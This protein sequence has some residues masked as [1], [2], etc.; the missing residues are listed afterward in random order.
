MARENEK[1]GYDAYS[2]AWRDDRYA[3]QA[4]YD[5]HYWDA[6]YSRGGRGYDANSSRH[7]Y[8]SPSSRRFYSTDAHRSS[9]PSRW[10][11][12]PSSSQHRY[13]SRHTP[14][15]YASS[16]YVL[17][18][19]SPP[20]RD[21][22]DDSRPRSRS[23]TPP[24]PGSP[25]PSYL[26][27]S[28]TPSARLTVPSR[29]L[30]I[31]DLNGAL[32][33]RSARPPRPARNAPPA[34]P[35]PRKVHRRPYLTTLRAYLF[36][37]ATRQWLDVMVWSSAQPHNV[38]DMVEHSFEGDRVNLLAVWARD[39]LGL[40]Q[41]HY[42]RKV[43]TVKDL[44]KPWAA[45][46]AL[47]SPP[48]PAASH[49]SIASSSPDSPRIHPEPPSALPPAN[50]VEHSA[51]TTLLLDDSPL[52][53][54]LQPYNHLCVPEYTQAQRNV[55][56]AELE[57]VKALQD[58]AHDV[59]HSTSALEAG[60]DEDS[61]IVKKRKRKEKKNLKAAARRA[62]GQADP[63]AGSTSSSSEQALANA[64]PDPQLDETLLA[65]VGI[66]HSVRLQDN[67]A[68]WVRSGGLWD[69][70]SDGPGNDAKKPS[71]DALGDGTVSM[72][73]Q[74]PETVGYWARKGR[75]AMEE[76]DLPVTHGV[77]R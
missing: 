64:N 9:S 2:P 24:D 23:A 59:A 53:A 50:D 15:P 19:S 66:L 51:L 28:E 5:A 11:D 74:D 10:S 49:S 8:Q 73:F 69:P 63:D 65:V 71:A 68:A 45:F 18:R 72:W 75:H 58:D 6:F 62:Q 47:L 22:V 67:V 60:A 27:L 36:S 34:P 77:D 16:P 39:T 25:T 54:V 7:P 17:P 41:D 48:S 33:L 43:Q 57:R 13:S 46:P 30:L 12:A 40:A 42:H 26:A 35:Q 55:D 29:K 37:D 1:Y 3:D 38:G 21:N 61:T 14:P 31:L 32:L 4:A 52:K 20:S 70:Q 76:L 44:A 56:L